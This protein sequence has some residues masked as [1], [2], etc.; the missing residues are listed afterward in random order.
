MA[1]ISEL[2]YSNAYSGSTG[3]AEFLEVAIGAN[4]DPADFTV[5]FY[6]ADGTFGLDINLQDGLDAGLI[7]ETIDPDNGERIYV[8]SSTNYPILLT[9][10]DG[11]VQQTTKPTR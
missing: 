8:I 11:G 6:Q 7:T 3:V 4:E 5:G 1:R 9:D 2:H 10:P